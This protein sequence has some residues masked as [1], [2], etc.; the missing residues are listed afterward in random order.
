MGVLRPVHNNSQNLFCLCGEKEVGGFPLPRK[1][2]NGP[3]IPIKLSSVKRTVC[4]LDVRKDSV[5]CCILCVDGRKI[6]HK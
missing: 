2:N 6:Q 5:F 4:G 3:D 1:L